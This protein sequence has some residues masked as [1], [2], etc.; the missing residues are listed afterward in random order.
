VWDGIN[1]S[2]TLYACN[3]N[4]WYVTASANQTGDNGAV[5]SYPDTNVTLAAPLISSFT[6]MTSNFR[7]YGTPPSCSGNDYEYAS[8]DWI[9]DANEWSDA[10]THTELMIWHYTCNQV[11][12]GTDVGTTTI[13]GRAFS[14]WLAGG[15]GQSNGD[16]VTFKAVTNYTSDQTDVLAFLQYAQSQGW[17]VSAPHFW[18]D[19][20]GA[21][22]CYTNG[23][24]TFG[25]QA[26]N[27]KI[28]GQPVS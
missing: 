4:S 11:P 19:G 3:K 20:E 14:V 26:F 13:N 10:S 17:L 16:I 9:G 23:Q 28:N 21:E 25:L 5:Q 15:L 24:Q 2:Q 6:S 1:I 22:L 7:I 8:D 18:Q 27:L 12:A